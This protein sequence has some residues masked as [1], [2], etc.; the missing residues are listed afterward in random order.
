MNDI[1]LYFRVSFTA[2][3]DIKTKEKTLNFIMELLWKYAFQS[4]PL[5]LDILY[6]GRNKS[7][8]II[9]KLMR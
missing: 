1:T 7:V 3:K 9:A 2:G 5:M 4:P 8:V 6:K